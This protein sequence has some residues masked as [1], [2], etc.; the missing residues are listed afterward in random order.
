[1]EKGR[2][3]ITLMM[4]PSRTCILREEGGETAAWQ[5]VGAGWGIWVSTLW[6]QE[7]LPKLGLLLQISF[8]LQMVPRVQALHPFLCHI[9]D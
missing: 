1:M 9:Q 2:E 6:L 3:G 5:V 4:A 7:M 8:P